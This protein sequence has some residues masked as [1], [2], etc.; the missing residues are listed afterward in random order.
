M[1]KTATLLFI[2]ATITP[3]LFAQPSNDNCSSAIALSEGTVCTNGSNVLA[4]TEPFEAVAPANQQC[5]LSVV[6]RTVWYKFTPTVTATY[7]VTTDNR[8]SD[9]TSPD[10]QIKL[11]TGTCGAFAMVSCSEDDG[12]VQA[13]AAQ[14]TATLNAGTTYFIQLDTYGAGT[15]TFCISVFRNAIAI[16][17][18]VNNAIDLT[19]MMN[20]VSSSNPYECNYG[21][22]YNAPGGG[23]AD[24]PIRQDVTGDPNGCNG[25]D[26]LLP[27][28]TNPDH[29]DVWFKFTKTAATPQSFL[30]LYP[31]NAYPVLWAMALYS[32]TPTSSC[33]NGNI[34]GLSYIDC[35]CGVLVDI[36]PG[37]EKGGARDV[38]LCS[39]PVHPRLDLRN[40][41]N[42]E[43][44][45][46]IWDFAGFTPPEGIFNLCFESTDPRAFSSDICSTPN[47]GYIGPLFNQGVNITYTNLSNAGTLGN[48]CNTAPNEPLLGATPAGQARIGC[49][50]PWITYVGAIN[51]VMN[52]TMIH[53]FSVN[54]CPGC[55][56]TAIIK[57]DNIVTDGTV[58]NVAQLQVMEPGNCSGSTQTIMNGSTGSNCIEMRVAANAPLP[59]GQYYIVVDGQDGQLMTYD[60]TVTIDYPC[61]PI[62]SC[63][64]L[65]IELL[66]FTGENIDKANKL[67]WAT[68]SETGNDYFDVERSNDGN[69]FK[70]IKKIEGSGTINSIS[71]YTT[72]DDNTPAGISYYRLKQVDF[73]GTFSYSPVISI[74]NKNESH[75]TSVIYSNEN[76]NIHL[77]FI[78][79]VNQKITV[80]TND[81]AGKMVLTNTFEATEGVNNFY[82]PSENLPQGIYFVQLYEQS[83]KTDVGRIFK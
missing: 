63:T 51:N 75:I 41:T 33:P 81:L 30:Q 39:T 80:K 73:D 7:T 68:A 49:A 14:V 26:P 58:G 62:G 71:Y 29:R 31:A 55:A 47:V 2:F 22:I 70:F 20:S 83:G 40:L 21:Y 52:V 78:S 82:I 19:T 66:T 17:D 3:A 74:K 48:S 79:P 5:W 4:T 38:S 72:Y 15:A 32:G 6:N 1:K 35:S 77:Q 16:N 13:L 43:Y 34:G 28:T 61:A 69:H 76:N 42:G 57:L 56:P 60:L 9:A 59:N 54:A 8:Q 53:S 67:D 27:L 11:L 36:P 23:V 18:C 37:N 46:R 25:Y 50:G 24:D 64:P 45:I 12:V 10:T 44:Y 65:P